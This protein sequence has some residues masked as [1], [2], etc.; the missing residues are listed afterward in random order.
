[1]TPTQHYFPYF[2]NHDTFNKELQAF[3][4]SSYVTYNSKTQMPD[5]LLLTKE[6]SKEMLLTI[7][8]GA[9]LMIQDSKLFYWITYANLIDIVQAELTN[10]DEEFEL[11]N[12]KIDL[13]QLQLGKNAI[14][15]YLDASFLVT[16]TRKE[17]LTYNQEYYENFVIVII[18]KEQINLIPFDWFN[19]TGGDYGYVWP[20]TARLD[21]SKCK[22]HGQGIR[23]SEFTVQLDKACL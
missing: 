17:G 16:Y 14:R 19:K 10:V 3:R 21:I 22:L 20:A 15:T 6:G 4:L 23:M 11:L 12:T 5:N 2:F 13:S 8:F 7:P 9:T 18:E 1:M